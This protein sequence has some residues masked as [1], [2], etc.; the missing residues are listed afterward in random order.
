[1]QCNAVVGYV[2]Q[3]MIMKF[4][5]SR[6]GKKNAHRICIN[7]CVLCVCVFRWEE[8]GRSGG[9]VTASNAVLLATSN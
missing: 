6:R 3:V 5:P 7:D 1:M 9:D 2:A 8:P 4:I